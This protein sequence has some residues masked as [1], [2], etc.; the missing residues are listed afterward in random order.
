MVAGPVSGVVMGA[1]VVAGS[2]AGVVV[3]KGV[4]VGEGVVAG[5]GAGVVMGV[6]AGTG[7]A[8]ANVVVGVVAGAIVVMG[9]GATLL[10]PPL[11]LPVVSAVPMVP[12]KPT[13]YSSTSPMGGLGSGKS[14]L[15]SSRKVWILRPCT[16]FKRCLPALCMVTAAVCLRTSSAIRDLSRSSA[17]ATSSLRSCSTSAS[18]SLLRRTWSRSVLL[19]SAALLACLT[20]ALPRRQLCNVRA[21]PSLRALRCTTTLCRWREITREARLSLIPCCLSSSASASSLIRRSLSTLSSLSPCTRLRAYRPLT[22]PCAR[23]APACIF[24]IFRRSTRPR[25]VRCSAT[26][27]S[28]W[29]CFCAS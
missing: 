7:V 19:P 1:G 26:A 28:F 9:A 15:C 24:A 13:Q 5:S 16:E 8:S 20:C 18:L 29:R 3:G 21:A 6:V 2:G 22:K 12:S 17:R 11:A 25:R 14:L 27:A 10:L 4:V 23:V